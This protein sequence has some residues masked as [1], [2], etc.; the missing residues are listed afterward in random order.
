MTLDKSKSSNLTQEEQIDLALA[1]KSQNSS[2]SLH[3]LAHIYNIP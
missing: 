1:E 2:L 3:W